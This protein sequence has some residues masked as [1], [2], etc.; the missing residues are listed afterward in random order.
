MKEIITAC[1]HLFNAH[2]LGQRG[3]FFIN[4]MSQLE[5]DTRPPV[6]RSVLKLTSCFWHPLE[7]IQYKN[8]YQMLKCPFSLSHLHVQHCQRIYITLPQITSNALSIKSNACNFSLTYILS[9]II[10]FQFG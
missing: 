7:S 4:I 6:L 10:Y 1:G 8:R 9:C 3:F 5:Y 2:V